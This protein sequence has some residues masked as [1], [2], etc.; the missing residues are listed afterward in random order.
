[1]RMSKSSVAIQNSLLDIVQYY[2]P[3]W[4]AKELV[5]KMVND[6]SNDGQ[7]LDY[8][9]QMLASVLLDGL[10]LGHWPWIK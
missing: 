3:D 10:R 8:I 7:S 6:A 9:V 1:M 2:A 5:I 4:E